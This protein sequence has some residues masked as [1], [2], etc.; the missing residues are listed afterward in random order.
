MFTWQTTPSKSDAIITK[1]TSRET[2]YLTVSFRGIWITTFRGKLIL[3]GIFWGRWRILGWICWWLI[4]WGLT[5]GGIGITFSLLGWILW[6]IGISS[7]ILYR[8][9]ITLVWRSI[10]ILWRELCLLWFKIPLEL[11]LTPSFRPVVTILPTRDTILSIT[12]SNTASTNW[13]STNLPLRSR[14]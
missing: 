11:D 6:L 7:L 13:S 10:A 3:R 9:T 1:N 4:I 14:W 5:R 8:L 2:R 12:T